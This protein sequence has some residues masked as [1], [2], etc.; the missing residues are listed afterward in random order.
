MIRPVVIIAAVVIAIAAIEL[1]TRV[2]GG[3]PYAEPERTGLSSLFEADSLLGYTT[4]PGLVE[5]PGSDDVTWISVRH[6]ED[7]SRAVEPADNY[8]NA[9]SMSETWV[10]GGSWQYGVGLEDQ[11]TLAWQI[12]DA[13]KE[14]PSLQTIVSN[15]AVAGYSA[16]QVYLMLRRAIEWGERPFVVTLPTR[17]ADVAETRGGRFNLAPVLGDLGYQFPVVRSADPLDVRHHRLTYQPLPFASSFAVVNMI[18]SWFRSSGFQQADGE[19]VDA[20][21]ALLRDHGIGVILL[22]ED[23]FSSRMT[24]EL[25][26]NSSRFVDLPISE[27]DSTAAIAALVA[28]AIAQMPVVD[29]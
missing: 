13:V 6:D 23:E 3:R 2:A 17:Y 8:L 10:V 25:R 14:L 27:S 7:G 1:F 9:S 28:E 26:I 11:E 19:L 29:P 22:N 18:D 16:S 20:T 24:R 12:Y 15:H 4:R 21:I 5:L